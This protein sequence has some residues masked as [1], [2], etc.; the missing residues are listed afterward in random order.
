MLLPR[1]DSHEFT[2]KEGKDFSAFMSGRENLPQKRFVIPNSR[3][4]EWPL[5][6][7]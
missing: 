1:F 5:H 3:R 2:M 7:P 6:L 4:G